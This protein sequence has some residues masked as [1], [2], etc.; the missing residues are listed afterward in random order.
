MTTTV[1]WPPRSISSLEHQLDAL[2]ETVRRPPD[3][4]TDDER[5]WLTRFLLLRAVGFLEQVV[6][7]CVREHVQIGSWGTV[8]S[9][10]TSFLDRSLNPSVDNLLTLLGRLDANLRDEFDT[11]INEDDQAILR[12]LSAAVALRHRI[13]HG[14]NEGI[15]EKRALEHVSTLKDVADWFI[16]KLNPLPQARASHQIQ[17]RK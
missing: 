12:G 4:R 3:E 13:A 11:W 1:S 14:L 9:F 17:G 10:S 16:R 7:E 2:T 6:N 15:G 5:V 8:R